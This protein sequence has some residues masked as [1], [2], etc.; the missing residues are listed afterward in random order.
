MPVARPASKPTMFL[1]PNAH[2]AK[3][4]SHNAHREDYKQNIHDPN[5]R[6]ARS[7]TIAP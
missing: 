1:S 3:D 7:L 4:N 6:R 2:R 5:N